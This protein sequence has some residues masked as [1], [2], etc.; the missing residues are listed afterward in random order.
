MP[1]VLNEKD[2][3]IV[4]GEKFAELIK[5]LPDIESAKVHFARGYEIQVDELPCVSVELG[6]DTPTDPDGTQMNGYTDSLLVIYLDIY[7]QSN[8]AV[9]LA[10]VYRQR[11]LCH[12][13]IMADFTLGDLVI[14]VRYG[15]NAEPIYDPETG[16]T[17]W[18]LRVPFVVHYRFNDSD[19]TVLI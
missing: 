14:Q 4:I 18:T 19:R 3:A 1:S 6:Q 10:R 9:G 15:G 12:K 17:G 16:L 2:A 13:A 7:D 5:A 8:S 11:A